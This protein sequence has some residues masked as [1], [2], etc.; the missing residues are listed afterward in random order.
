MQ[1]QDESEVVYESVDVNNKEIFQEC[2]NICYE[3]ISR[4]PNNTAIRGLEGMDQKNSSNKIF[5]V[6]FTI[7]LLAFIL[8]LSCTIAFTFEISKLKQQYFDFKNNTVDS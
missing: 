1:L 2:T 7:L 8:S 3:G 5:A 4:K 6:L